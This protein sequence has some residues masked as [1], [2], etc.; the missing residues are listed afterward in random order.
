MLLLLDEH[1]S[2]V[3]IDFFYWLNVCLCV[4]AKYLSADIALN[5]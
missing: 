3:L 5:S 4:S 2:L 1:A